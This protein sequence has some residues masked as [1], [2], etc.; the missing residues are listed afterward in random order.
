[1]TPQIK[2]RIKQI[3]RGEVPEGYIK[4]KDGVFPADW[5]N[6]RMKQWISLEER[7]IMLQ[8]EDD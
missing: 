8:D 7:P 4:I 1:M 3:Q 6:K 5:T 2:Q